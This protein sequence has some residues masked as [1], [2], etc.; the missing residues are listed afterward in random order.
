MVWIE[1]LFDDE[2]EQATDVACRVIPDVAAALD[3]LI[4]ALMSGGDQTALRRY[5]HFVDAAAQTLM[6]LPSREPAQLPPA[7]VICELLHQDVVELPWVAPTQDGRGIITVVVDR[8]RGFAAGIPQQCVRAPLDVDEHRFMWFLKSM[9]SVELER[10]S[11]EPLR[12]AMDIL[13]LS[14]ADVAGLIGVRRQA[15]DK[16]LLAGPPVDRAKKIG[17]VAEIADILQYRLR[18][19]MPPVVARRSAEVYGD[20][21]MLDLIEAD[22]EEWLL[23][24]VRAS[25]DYSQVA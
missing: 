5:V 4:P 3:S 21:S 10:R 24:S 17:T 20:R 12:R 11:S 2:L 15:V 1:E 16:W 9:A 18:D 25:F 6:A 7:V 8:L 19:G 13:D 23:R 22:E 14:S